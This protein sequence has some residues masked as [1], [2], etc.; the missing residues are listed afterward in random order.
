VLH[1]LQKE[2]QWERNSSITFGIADLACAVGL[3][4]TCIFLP[5][6]TPFAATGAALCYAA[7]VGEFGVAAAYQEQSDNLQAD[8]AKTSKMVYQLGNFF[9]ET[10]TENARRTLVL[11]LR[12]TKEKLEGAVNVAAEIEGEIEALDFL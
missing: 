12:S 2:V 9:D 5:F 1:G 3:T 8:I 10:T 6:L 4:L 11:A 7:A